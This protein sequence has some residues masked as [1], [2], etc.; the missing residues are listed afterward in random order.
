VNTVYL[1]HTSLLVRFEKT[2]YDRTLKRSWFAALQPNVVKTAKYQY[3]NL[4][5]LPAVLDAR[6]MLSQEN[7]KELRNGA[8]DRY[9]H[10]ECVQT[11]LLP[12]GY[13]FPQD[14]GP[15]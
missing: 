5:L 12:G 7:D 4:A 2:E 3:F 13:P 8:F 14:T 11:V 1:V 10:L 15:R 9:I 6:Q